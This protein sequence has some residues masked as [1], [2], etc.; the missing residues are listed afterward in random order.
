VSEEFSA[1]LDALLARELAN[2]E[3]RGLPVEAGL[4]P[5]D[6][7]T[8]LG[9]MAALKNEVRVETRASRELRQASGDALDLLRGELERVGAREEKLRGDIDEARRAERRAAAMILVDVLDRLTIESRSLQRMHD[10]QGNFWPWQ[11]R[12]KARLASLVEGRELTVKRVR[13]ELSGLN[14]R[15]IDALGR[16]FDPQIME[17]VDTV[18]LAELADGQVVE[19][20]TAGYLLGE[21]PLRIAQVVVNRAAPRRISGENG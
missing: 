17:A 13:D 16:G 1:D 14:V 18:E 9:E 20:V 7:Q 6:L 10:G 4:P 19:E 12:R 11:K 5:V 8:L 2:L 3:E 15:S 21:R